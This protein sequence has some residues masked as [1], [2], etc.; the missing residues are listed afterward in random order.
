MRRLNQI[1]SCS[2]WFDRRAFGLRSHKVVRFG[3]GGLPSFM[4]ASVAFAG[5]QNPRRWEPESMRLRSSLNSVSSDA[6]RR[7]P[8]RG[9]GSC[10]RAQMVGS[11]LALALAMFGAAARAQAPERYATRMTVVD[12]PQQ[13][14]T[15]I[16][17]SFT[18][19]PAYIARFSDEKRRLIV[20]VMDAD[21]KGIKDTFSRETG[22]VKSVLTQAFGAAGQR[23]T[24]F[25]IALGVP[26]QAAISIEDKKLV[27]RL[28]PAGEAEPA[29]IALVDGKPVALPAGKAQPS[30]TPGAEAAGADAANAPGAPQ[31]APAPGQAKP[32]G[33]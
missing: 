14:A 2:F 30:R 21:V 26:G 6:S 11:M 4:G 32:A 12:Q 7:A 10:L 22:L 9:L 17:I 24:R 31:A 13:H 19:A 15:V 1:G 5:S 23:T 27:I 25:L 3:T 16:E 29:P 8:R 33:S 28:E 18:Q 20:D